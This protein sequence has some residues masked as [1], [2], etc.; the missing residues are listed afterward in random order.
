MRVLSQLSGPRRVA[1]LAVVGF[2]IVGLA[3]CG[4]SGATPSGQAAQSHQASGNG[5]VTNS[6]SSGS[7]AV[8]KPTKIS[9]GTGSIGQ[10]DPTTTIPNER[11]NAIPNVLAPGQNIIISKTGCMPQ[12]LE[13]NVSAPVVWTNLSGTP[14]R[15]VFANFGVDSGT[16]PVG[17]TFTWSTQDAVA[18]GYKVEPSGKVC[19]LLMNPVQP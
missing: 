13:A 6:T 4:S 3:S 17:G 14:Q 11:G 5:R 9:F 18:M 10:P 1:T 19:H 2:S 16:I 8:D 7:S 12:T 15:V